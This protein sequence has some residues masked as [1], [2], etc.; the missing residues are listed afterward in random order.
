MQGG[1]INQGDANL[2]GEITGTNEHVNTGQMLQ[3]VAVS[4]GWLMFL[5]ITWLL[6]A[7]IAYG[8][9]LLWGAIPS[10]AIHWSFFEFT[11]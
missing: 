1:V 10:L 6:I 4:L 3:P 8:L 5:R 2:G 11:K 7:V 9:F